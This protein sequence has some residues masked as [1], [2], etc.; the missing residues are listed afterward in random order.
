MS[1][2]PEVGD[3]GP[4]DLELIMVGLSLLLTEAGMR[5]KDQEFK[6]ATLAIA[7][8]LQDRTEEMA[9][10]RDALKAGSNGASGNGDHP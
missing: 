1:T 4:N 5:S 8:R 3:A 2:T 10:A 9:V 7:Q 6:V